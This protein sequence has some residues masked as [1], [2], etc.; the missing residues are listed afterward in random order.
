MVSRREQPE[1]TCGVV[2][3]KAPC[4]LGVVLVGVACVILECDDVN[5]RRAV[6][7]IV[8]TYNILQRGGVVVR[9]IEGATWAAG[10]DE[11]KSLSED[12]KELWE[13]LRE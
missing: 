13:L 8:V 2:P 1:G 7:V 9:G 5:I 10:I 3:E 11:V 6:R 4:T 12:T